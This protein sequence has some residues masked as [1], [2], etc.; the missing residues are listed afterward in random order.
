M[1]F[2]MNRIRQKMRLEKERERGKT[3]TL[4]YIRFK[5]TYNSHFQL[6]EEMFF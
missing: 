5:L 3:L 1:G 4:E 6:P 2:I